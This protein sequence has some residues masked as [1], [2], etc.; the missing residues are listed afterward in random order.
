MALNAMAPVRVFNLMQ[1]IN[2]MNNG[3][4]VFT[5]NCVEGIQA[6]KE[7]MEN[8]VAKSAGTITAISP[9]IGY[10]LASKIAW[11]AI[12]EGKSVR[13]LCSQYDVLSEEQLNQ[14]FNPFEMTKPWIAGGDLVKQ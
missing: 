8:Y 10:E 3:F 9:H 12:M 7:Q 2:V 5:D 11:E 1:S 6:N 13:E 14:I 4:R